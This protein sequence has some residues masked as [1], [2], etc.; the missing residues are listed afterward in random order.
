MFKKT[1]LIKPHDSNSCYDFKFM[2][3]EK[4]IG[5]QY[6]VKPLMI[7]T[8]TSKSMMSFKENK[9]IIIFQLI[10]ILDI[11]ITTQGI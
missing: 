10:L 9:L 6:G 2:A 8:R 3:E 1:K 7:R 11:M 4:R 5:F